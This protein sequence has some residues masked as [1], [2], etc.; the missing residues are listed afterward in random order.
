VAG[1]RPKALLILSMLM[2]LTPS[3]LY[4]LGPLRRPAMVDGDQLT[5]LACPDCQ[6]SGS[7][8]GVKCS[9]C[10]GKKLVQHVVPSAQRPTYVEGHVY[11]PDQSTPV[12]GAKVTFDSS[13]GSWTRQTDEKGRFGADL[14][15]GEY[16]L[17]IESPQGKLST[18]VKVL[19]Q[20]QPSPV[21][22]EI[23]FPVRHDS[24]TLT[25]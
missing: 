12:A 1:V 7:K 18:V 6:G 10:R 15:P 25:P 2:M 3:F 4:W 20:T 22:K 8:E 14:P 13:M 16:P 23:T 11:A 24:F 21:D 5:M 17:K 9:R 19:P